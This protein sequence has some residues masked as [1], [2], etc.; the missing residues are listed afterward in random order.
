MTRGGNGPGTLGTGDPGSLT[1]VRSGHDLA[2]WGIERS[3]PS[4][5]ASSALS[6]G[7]L[8]FGPLLIGAPLTHRFLM[9][10]LALAWVP[11]VAALG[12]EAADGAGRRWLTYACGGVFVLFLPNAPYLVS[13]LTHLRQPSDTPWLDLARLFTFAWA[14]CVLC[15]ASLRIVHGVASARR[16]PMVGWLLVL[17]AAVASGAGV[18]IGRFARLNSWEVATRPNDVGTEALSL[19]ESGQAVSVAIFFTALVLV[20]YVALARVTISR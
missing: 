6:V 14:G 15:A 12:V 19:V 16:G 20:V 3:L 10:N 13:D 5:V 18:A 1:T 17:C 2:R 11:F 8:L 7:V 9:W 4:V